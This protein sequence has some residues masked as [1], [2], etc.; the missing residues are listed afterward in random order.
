MGIWR[1]GID[2]LSYQVERIFAMNSIDVKSP[3]A[4]GIG[5]TR[6]P[7]VA[8]S[9]RAKLCQSFCDGS[10]ETFLPTNIGDEELVDPMVVERSRKEMRS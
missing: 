6:R 9:Q 8:L 4:K 10:G 2:C 5:G 3:E 1:A 7:P